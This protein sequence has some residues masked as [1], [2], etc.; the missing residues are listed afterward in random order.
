MVKLPADKPKAHNPSGKSNRDTLTPKQTKILHIVTTKPN[1]TT[2][3]VAKICDTDHSY[4]VQ[5]MQRYN[6][7]SNIVDDYKVNRADIFAG[8]Q[9]RLVS[10]ITDAEIKKAAIGTR[11]LA[12]CQMYDKE[13]LERGMSTSNL[14]SVHGDIAALR[15]VDK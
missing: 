13:R 6:I 7:T 2:R 15:A 5:V 11:I 10:S 12:A 1:L 9:H 8:L 3:E 14:L 4:V